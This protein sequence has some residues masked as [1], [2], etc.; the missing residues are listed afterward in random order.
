MVRWRKDLHWED[1]VFQINLKRFDPVL[2]FAA[3]EMKKYLRM[4]MPE[5]DE[6]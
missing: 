5:E 1:T 4:M 3:E 6:I 2:V